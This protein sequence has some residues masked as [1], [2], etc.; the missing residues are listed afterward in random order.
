M[1]QG[2]SRK[3]AALLNS[4]RFSALPSRIQYEIRDELLDKRFESFEELEDKI[5]KAEQG[6]K[7]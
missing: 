5:I 3:I 7:K 2:D 1:K 6:E 4:K